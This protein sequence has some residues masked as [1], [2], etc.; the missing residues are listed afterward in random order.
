M[1]VLLSKEILIEAGKFDDRRSLT[2]DT[3]RVSGRLRWRKMLAENKVRAPVVHAA[4][5]L[6]PQCYRKCIWLSISW[7]FSSTVSLSGDA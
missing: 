4:P 5:L 7:I 6:Y 3:V 2:I 1:I